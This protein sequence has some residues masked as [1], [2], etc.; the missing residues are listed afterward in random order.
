M[1]Q[2]PYSLSVDASNDAG[3]SKMNPLTVR[4]FDE[5]QNI[6][7]IYYRLQSIILVQC[8]LNE[9]NRYIRITLL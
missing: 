1:K 8:D 6:V 4:L 2:Q 9:A 3:Q 5:R 7:H